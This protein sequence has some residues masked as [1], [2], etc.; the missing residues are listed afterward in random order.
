MRL[1]NNMMAKGPV[2]QFAEGR[3]A[4]LVI[5]YEDCCAALEAIAE[6]A[7]DIDVANKIAIANY[8]G[9]ENI[10]DELGSIPKTVVGI[11]LL[12][13][14]MEDDIALVKEYLNGG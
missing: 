3:L 4:S 14:Q 7:P 8:I 6:K 2:K 5:E 10:P 11:D 1:Q 13:R 12:T 9:D